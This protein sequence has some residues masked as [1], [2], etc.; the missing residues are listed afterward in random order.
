MWVMNLSYNFSQ[1]LWVRTAV[2]THGTRVNLSS[3]PQGCVVVVGCVC[4][5][6]NDAEQFVVGDN[7][8]EFCGS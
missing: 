5:T 8:P 2:D 7:E 6:D 4:A 3:L 1:P